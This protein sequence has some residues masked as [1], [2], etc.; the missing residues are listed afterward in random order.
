V[1]SEWEADAYPTGQ[2]SVSPSFYK[3]VGNTIYCP[4]D[5]E[6]TYYQRIPS[7]VADQTNWLLSAAP[8]AYLYGCLAAY[9]V[10]DK[11]PELVTGYR[12]LMANVLGGLGLADQNSRAGSF[13]RRS[14]MPAY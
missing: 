5:L 14:S 12:S 8:T 10:W 1:T 6:L 4:V 13:T 3:I 11:N 7:L 9:S 2:A